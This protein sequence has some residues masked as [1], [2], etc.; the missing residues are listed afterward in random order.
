MNKD[1]LYYTFL[2]IISAL[3]IWLWLAPVG[4]IK[5]PIAHKTQ[6]IISSQNI[7]PKRL[8]L[9]CWRT[10]KNRYVDSKMNG[11]D[12][13]YWKNHYL[14]YIKTD[15]DVFVAVNSML[16]SL[17][18]PYSRFMDSPQNEEQNTNLE[19]SITGI[20]VNIGLVSGKV[21]ISNVMENS[22]AKK[23]NLQEGDIITEINGKKINGLTME[24]VVKL[25]RGPEN[26][27][28]K[29][30]ILRDK[31]K[32]VKDTN[33]KT[34][35][36]KNVKS[37]IL[38]GNI[39]YIQIVSFMGMQGS[40]EFKEALKTTQ[41]TNG[42]IIDLRGDA[43]GL[44]TNAVD[45]AN[46][47][48][49][50]GTIV[51]V[52]YRSGLRKKITA[53]HSAFFKEKPIVILTNMGTAS[54]S[55]ILAGTLR[56]NKEAILVGDRTYGKNSIQQIFALPNQ[57]GMNLTI[58]KYLMPKGEYIHKIGLKP[59]YTVVLTKQDYI[60]NNDTQLKKAID[61]INNKMKHSK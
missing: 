55:E 14:P 31:T 45:I 7:Q 34:I 51:S 25:I 33:R 41:N 57:T 26:S 50:K 5:A 15:E 40:E 39:G 10:I 60:E 13:E 30:T 38:K 22:P 59:D 1:T 54:A 12:W 19:S 8:F 6:E 37:K 52:V 53:S 21:V 35:K 9:F 18:D 48:I 36:I 2:S 23:A 16:Q 24:E 46:M 11:Q 47:F 17:D 49:N 32:I 29:L 4:T 27:N 42:L 3:A 43:G 58:A 61:I 56:D 20:G 28:V 44:L